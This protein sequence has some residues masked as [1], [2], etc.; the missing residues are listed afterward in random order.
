MNKLS[1]GTSKNYKAT[2]Y[3]LADELEKVEVE[4]Y[5]FDIQN[6]HKDNLVKITSSLETLGALMA[7]STSSTN[8]DETIIVE[9]KDKS[10]L[11]WVNTLQAPSKYSSEFIKFV[12]A[13]DNIINPLHF[14]YM[15]EPVAIQ[16][17]TEYDYNKCKEK[18]SSTLD[19]LLLMED[20]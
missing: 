8:N 17:A 11:K 10:V 18:L 2:M 7:K 20:E 1:I 16:Y 12:N 4:P 14:I 5:H 9:I 19:D 15:E 3:V 6:I 13:M